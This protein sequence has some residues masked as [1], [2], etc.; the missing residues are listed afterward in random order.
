M[1]GIDYVAIDPGIAA[2]L[3]IVRMAEQLGQDRH[4]VAGHFPAFFGRVAE[5]CPTGD[6]SGV[7]PFLLDVW[8]GE[9]PGWGDAVL[10]HLCTDDDG[11]M[12]GVLRSWWKYNG[13]ALQNLERDRQRKRERRRTVRGQSG[14]RPDGPEDTD[15]SGR[16]KSPES[17]RKVHGQSVERPESDPKRP[18]SVESP[19]TVRD[20][21]TG[22]TDTDTD[23]DTEQLHTP[24]ARGRPGWD[25]DL[26][27]EHLPEWCRE[28]LRT[29]LEAS[30]RGAP[31]AALAIAQKCG[32]DPTG[33]PTGPEMKGCTVDEMA[34]VLKRRA[35]ATQQAWHEAF[36][37]ECLISIRRGAR[38]ASTDAQPPESPGRRVLRMAAE[39]DQRRGAASS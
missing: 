34:E 28:F 31:M 3:R 19:G 8:A 17:P 30:G 39:A 5:H 4:W 36:A 37:N 21:S 38:K 14:E 2:D 13:K 23:T 9:V 6:L 12:T 33:I 29:V 22:N 26:L 25:E 27:M 24:R 15:R 16:G 18:E 32:L 20:R 7:P 10:E 35:T 11:V 1:K